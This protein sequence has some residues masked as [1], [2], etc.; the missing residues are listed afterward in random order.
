MNGSVQDKPPPLPSEEPLVIDGDIELGDLNTSPEPLSP[1]NG[2]VEQYDDF[3]VDDLDYADDGNTALLGAEG[4]TRGIE[5]LDTSRWSQV[6]SIVLEVCV[7]SQRAI[8]GQSRDE[9]A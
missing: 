8:R 6:N 1:K 3:G 5:R 9:T 2:L 7:R 4:R